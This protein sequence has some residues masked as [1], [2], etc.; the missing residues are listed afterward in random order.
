MLTPVPEECPRKIL[1]A[2][3]DIMK[4]LHWT[5]LSVL[6]AFIDF[7]LL[8]LSSHHKGF[9]SRHFNVNC[10]WNN[11]FKNKNYAHVTF[12]FVLWPSDLQYNFNILYITYIKCTWLQNLLSTYM[13]LPCNNNHSKV[14]CSWGLLRGNFVQMT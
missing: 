6:V 5:W 8:I 4:F 14:I 11:R 2:S 7:I 9:S 12:A 10:W 3:W 1:G 13:I